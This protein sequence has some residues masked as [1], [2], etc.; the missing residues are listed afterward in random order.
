MGR[1]KLVEAFFNFRRARS[2]RCLK[3]RYNNKKHYADEVFVRDDGCKSEYMLHGRD[4]AVL[5]R[6]D[7]D[8]VLTLWLDNHGIETRL[9]IDTLNLILKYLKDELGVDHG[10]SYRLKYRYGSPDIAYIR[11]DGKTYLAI[12]PNRVTIS[13]MRGVKR[14]INVDLGVSKDKEIYFFRDHPELRSLYNLYRRFVRLYREVEALHYEYYK[15]VSKTDPESLVIIRDMFRKM[16]GED[17][18]ADDFDGLWQE[19]YNLE[20]NWGF[21]TPFL[22]AELVNRLGVEYLR[23]YLRDKI[24]LAERVLDRYK[25]F[26]AFVSL[27][28]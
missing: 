13:F 25:R 6:C 26:L 14:P 22:Y 21:H 8:G 15:C 19:L 20:A 28:R 11:Y 27:I 7:N 4:I 12:I 23:N 2:I 3:C 16:Y 10:V 18:S 17:L 24:A 5:T 1:E 9:F